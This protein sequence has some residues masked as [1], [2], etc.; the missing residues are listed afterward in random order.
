[1]QRIRTPAA[2]KK[3]S[4]EKLPKDAHIL[5]SKHRQRDPDFHFYE[6]DR[7][8]VGQINNLPVTRRILPR[9][10]PCRQRSAIAVN[11]RQ[12]AT[13]RAAGALWKVLSREQ[14]LVLAPPAGRYKYV[15]KTLRK[16]VP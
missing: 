13:L 10:L 15:P 1:M 5:K 14:A 9:K 3:Y 8:F 12:V 11:Y 2:E 4:Q 16:R 7:V 6:N